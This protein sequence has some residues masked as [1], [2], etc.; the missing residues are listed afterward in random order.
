M[1]LARKEIT[2]SGQVNQGL[3]S[4]NIEENQLQGLKQM[5]KQKRAAE[6]EEKLKEKELARLNIRRE[7]YERNHGFLGNTKLSESSSLASLNSSSKPDAYNKVTASYENKITKTKERKKE[8]DPIERAV[9][10]DASDRLRDSGDNWKKSLDLV[11]R[12]ARNGKSAAV[13]AAFDKGLPVDSRDE[14]QNTILI[15]AGNLCFQKVIYNS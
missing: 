9:L 8:M 4:R 12:N 15:V 7:S 1:D 5:Q 13:N 3:S 2:R 10:M 6:K 11:F 14:H